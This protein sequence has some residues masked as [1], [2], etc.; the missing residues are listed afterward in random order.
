MVLK[1]GWLVVWFCECLRLLF[2]I[3]VEEYLQRM[4]PLLIRPPPTAITAAINRCDTI[5]FEKYTLPKKQKNTSQ[6]REHPKR[7]NS[8]YKKQRM[9]ELWFVYM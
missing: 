8:K 7:V 9:K 2:I 5:A 4:S 3:V 1:V 6:Q